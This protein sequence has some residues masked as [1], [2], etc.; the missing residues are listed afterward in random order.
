MSKT[1]LITGAAGLLG[2]NFSRYLTGK[3]YTVVGID[4]LFGGYESSDRGLIMLQSGR[5]DVD[6]TRFIGN[7]YYDGGSA[8]VSI[9]GPIQATNSTFINNSGGNQYWQSS[10]IQFSLSEPYS[11]FESCVFFNNQGFVMGGPNSS[12]SAS[13]EVTVNNCIIYEATIHSP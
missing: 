12:S 3:G 13:G 7:N 9:N 10:V 4:N 1:V 2:A 5:I 8:I 6:S 11:S